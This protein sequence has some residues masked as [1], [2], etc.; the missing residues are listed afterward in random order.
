MRRVHDPRRRPGAPD[1]M[2][3][4]L[5]VKARDDVPAI[6][7]GVLDPRGDGVSRR[8][9]SGP[10]RSPVSSGGAPA[11]EPG[12]RVPDDPAEAGSRIMGRGRMRVRMPVAGGQ[13]AASRAGASG[14]GWKNGHRMGPWGGRKSLSR[15][16]RPPSFFR[17]WDRRPMS[18]GR[19]PSHGRG[20]AHGPRRVPGPRGAGAA[21]LA[22][23]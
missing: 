5:D 11:A 19:E 8:R 14:G 7:R 23:E 16:A 21:G 20:A 3:I 22:A 13:R 9:L 6:P 12:G 1:I 18:D 2:K 17:G 4:G 10:S 15:V